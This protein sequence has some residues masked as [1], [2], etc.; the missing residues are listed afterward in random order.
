MSEV[1]TPQ[2]MFVGFFVFLELNDQLSIPKNNLIYDRLKTI[3]EFH[4]QAPIHSGNE[5]DRNDLKAY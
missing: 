3:H 2:N 5:F 1:Y 4:H